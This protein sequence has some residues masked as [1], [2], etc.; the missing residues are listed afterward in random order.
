MA[1]TTKTLNKSVK[2][3]GVRTVS[4]GKGGIYARIPGE[5]RVFFG[6]DLGI[7]DGETLTGTL[8]LQESTYT[9]LSDGVPRPDGPLTRIEAEA[10]TPFS[11]ELQ[12]ALDQAKLAAIPTMQFKPEMFF[13]GTA[14]ATADAMA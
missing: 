7:K 9:E 10:F 1:S 8:W 13:A 5:G 14:K 4:L 3:T 11:D 12:G 2:I 6:V